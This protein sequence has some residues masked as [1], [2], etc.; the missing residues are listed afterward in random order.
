MLRTERDL[1]VLFLCVWSG[2]RGLRL[3][4]WDLRQLPGERKGNDRTLQSYPREVGFSIPWM[5]PAGASAVAGCDYRTDPQNHW[6]ECSPRSS[7]MDCFHCRIFLCWQ[8]LGGIVDAWPRLLAFGCGENWPRS[9]SHTITRV[10]RLFE[11]WWA[12]SCSNDSE[13]SGHLCSYR[14][15]GSFATRPPHP[16]RWIIKATWMKW[17]D[18]Y[19]VFAMLWIYHCF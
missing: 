17:F 8:I 14:S 7:S 19:N 9:D 4:S 10:V 11:A 3:G 18:V 13:R 15:M 16:R 1:F 5:L 2:P 12:R 6:T